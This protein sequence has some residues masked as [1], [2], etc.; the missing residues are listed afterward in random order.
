MARR[1]PDDDTSGD[2]DAPAIGHNGGP[3]LDMGWTAWVWRRAHANAWKSPG[4][5][6]VM[7]RMRRCERLGLSY[8]Q[9]TAALLDTGTHLGG[10]VVM[11]DTVLRLHD[12]IVL[13]KLTTLRDCRLVLCGEGAAALAKALPEPPVIVPADDSVRLSQIVRAEAAILQAPTSV[14]FLVGTCAA[15]RALTERLRVGL[16]VGAAGYFGY[17]E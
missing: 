1:W 14:F 3:P 7:L 5:E 10:A 16:Y 15:H 2:P 9:Y 17:A 4:R 8:R 12:D 11:C 6:I 13:R